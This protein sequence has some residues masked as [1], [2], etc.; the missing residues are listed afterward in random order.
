MM[1]SPHGL[2]LMILFFHSAAFAQE[3]E[4]TTTLAFSIRQ[5]RLQGNFRSALLMTNNAPGLTDYQVA[6]T[7]GHLLYQT[8][9]FK[10]LRLAAGIHFTFPV[11]SSD[12][13][14]ADP[15]TS[16][17]SR[18]ESTLLD[19]THPSEKRGLAMISVLNLSWHWKQ[20]RI[21]MGRQF[22]NTP[23]INMQDNRIQPNSVEGIYT[24][25]RLKK[26]KVEAGWL[27]R[28]APRGTMHWYSVAGSMGL[29]PRGSNSDGSRG[30]YGGNIRTKG[31]ALLGVHFKPGENLHLQVWEQYA[32]NLFNTML[33]Q[34]DYKIP[35]GKNNRWLLSLQY[36]R[37]DIINEGGNPDPAKT[38]FSSNKVNIAG[39]RTGWESKTVR[40][41]LNYTRIGSGG[42][43]AMPRE[44]GTE[45]FFTFLNRERN[46]GAGDVQ[47]VS[48]TVK[49]EFP[50]QR[51]TM[52]LGYGRYFM[53][54][55]KQYALNKYGL[56]SYDH[57][58]ITIDYVCGGML[59][60]LKLSALYIYKGE[61]GNTYGN[62][63]YVINKVN[64]SHFALIVN[65]PF[66]AK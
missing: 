23:F 25:I 26:W 6:A 62:L 32:D 42:R 18:Y 46:E 30:D 37:Q 47:A 29:Y 24:D 55:V 20:N 5:G 14:K 64:M 53:P 4:D 56:S 22:L 7:G 61:K 8:G 63:K 19:I 36:I 16:A 50:K 17:A 51:I 21:T 12:L 10:G 39:V 57:T 43:F 38:Y 59:R 52:E 44:W 28:I 65:Y 66:P 54:D 35:S 15:V 41:L 27:Y 9:S 45:P 31:I 34:G 40:L 58:K 13:S 48:A 11:F 49:K 3:K 60:N 1:R 33:V 2:F